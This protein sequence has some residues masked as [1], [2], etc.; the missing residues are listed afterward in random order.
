VKRSEWHFN[1]NSGVVQY[2]KDIKMKE[3]RKRTKIAC[4]RVI[5]LPEGHYDQKEIGNGKIARFSTS[6]L[7]NRKII[8]FA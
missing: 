5:K 8:N 3:N 6:K 2:P 7:K 1:E 4:H